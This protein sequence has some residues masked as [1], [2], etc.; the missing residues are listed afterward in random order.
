MAG[1][2]IGTG[3][4]PKSLWPG[5]HAHFGRIYDQHE[6]EYPK[7]FEIK[8][9]TQHYEE[10][11]QI[12]GFGLVPVKPEGRGVEFT[13]ETQGWLKRYTHVVYGMGYIVT[14]EEEEDN[15]YEKVSKTR[16]G[17][18][19]FAMRQTEEN[20]CA[21]VVN[22]MTDTNYVGGDSSVLVCSTHTTKSGNQSN[23]L[24]PAADLSETALEDLI[25]MVYGAKD[26]LGLQIKLM[27]ISLIVPR[28]EWFN[29]NRILESVLQNDTAL[30]AQ[31]VLKSTNALPGG[32]VMNH[33]LTDTDAFGVKT[34]CPNGLTYF[35]RREYEFTVDSDFSSEN[36]LAKATKRF[37][38]GW[39]DWR[40]YFASPGA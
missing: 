19:A 37:S 10:D 30:N 26:D 13:S 27:P 34:N 39:T 40:T 35:L 31:N 20:V 25:I 23:I 28:Q 22:R 38:V 29:A 8:Q 36:M 11:V 1:G 32:I 24:S 4:H 5:I 17:S 14:R 33:Y 12:T 2:I 3:N 21:N 9:S 16:S 7:L 6:E 18:L 15:L